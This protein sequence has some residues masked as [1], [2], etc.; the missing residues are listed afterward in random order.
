MQ[1]V[2]HRVIFGKPEKQ[3]T[4]LTKGLSG[5]AGTF[6]EVFAISMFENFKLAEQLDKEKKF[7]SLPAV[8]QHLARTRGVFGGFYIGYFGMQIRQCLWTGTFF[9]TLDV[10]KGVMGQVTSN[11]LIGDIGSGFCAGASGVAMNCWTDVVRSVIQKKAVADTFNPE[12][13]APNALT[14]FSP[15]PF[16]KEAANVM[17]ERG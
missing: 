13:K 5:A 9:L 12:I 16:F 4:P 2:C 8:A 7:K 6:P 15:G 1:P 3:G 14:H 10:Y 11:K 17:G